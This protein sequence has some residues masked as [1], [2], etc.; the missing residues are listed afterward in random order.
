MTTLARNI[1]HIV[2]G[3]LMAIITVWLCWV[4]LAPPVFDKLP[5]APVQQLC[6]APAVVHSVSCPPPHLVTTRKV[7]CLK[8]R[9]VDQCASLTP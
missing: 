2:P 6:P 8:V 7:K 9:R 4:L 1:P 5:R 3:H